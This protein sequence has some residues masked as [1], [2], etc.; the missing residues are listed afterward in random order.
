VLIVSASAMPAEID[1]MIQAGAA[2]Y[3]TK[4]LDV[5]LFLNTIDTF[6]IHTPEK[7]L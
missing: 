5:P 4:P 3:L 2:S 1:S 6:L 7:A